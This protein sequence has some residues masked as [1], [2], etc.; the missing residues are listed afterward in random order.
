MENSKG[1][2]YFGTI[3]SGLFKYIPDNDSFCQYG[4]GNNA[5]PSDYCYYICESPIYRHLLILHSK[6]FSSS[7]PKPV[8]ASIHTIYFKWDIAR[9]KH[10]FRTKWRNLYRRSKRHAFFSKNNSTTATIIIISILISCGCITH[11]YC[12]MMKPES[13]ANTLASKRNQAFT[14]PEQSNLRVLF[15][16]LYIERRHHL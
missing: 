5:L 12:P 8:K 3:G 7:I 16:Q 9:V 6:G 10:L 11:A 15:L 13:L 4:L 1:E 14:R 2:I